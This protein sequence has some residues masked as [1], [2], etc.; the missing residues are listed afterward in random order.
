M[1]NAVVC[2]PGQGVHASNLG[3]AELQVDDTFFPCYGNP[4]PLEVVQV[5]LQ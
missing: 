5:Q 4:N 2:L 1:V 3:T